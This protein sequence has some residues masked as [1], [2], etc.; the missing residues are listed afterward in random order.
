MNSSLPISQRLSTGILLAFTGGFLD[1]YTFLLKGGVFANGQTGNIALMGFHL[2][3]GNFARAGRYLVPVCA[4]SLGVMLT[5]TVRHRFAGFEKI[6]WRQCT[7]LIE[8][9]LLFCIGC[10][11]AQVPY[12]LVTSLI[13]TICGIQVASFRLVEGAPYASTMC[14]GNLRSISEML[15]LYLFYGDKSAGK[16]ILYYLTIIFCFLTGAIAG[17]GLI[18]IFQEPAIWFCCLLLG[19]V[20][21]RLVRHPL[22]PSHQAHP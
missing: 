4:F 17:T 10:F 16:S 19:I 18:G 22:E 1:I 5:E 15:S 6:H 21:I 8:I 12:L 13:S 3:S 2:A 11:S 20:L 7:T 9:V 14:T